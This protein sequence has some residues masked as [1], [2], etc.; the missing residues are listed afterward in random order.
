[1]L[2]KHVGYIADALW[3]CTVVCPLIIVYWS[4]T[5]RLLDLM[6]GTSDPYL[7]AYYC[8]VIGA[9]ANVTGYYGLPLLS[10]F[11]GS[12]D[13]LQHILISRLFLYVYAFNVIVYWRGVWNFA[14]LLAG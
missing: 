10:K 13:G 12:L 8:L 14:D 6:C 1:M 11:A 7:G 5:W 4:G 9:V 3:S 2:L